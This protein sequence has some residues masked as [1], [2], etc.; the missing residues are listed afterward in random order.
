[1]FLPARLVPA[2]CSVP[3]VAAAR[4][5]QLAVGVHARH[6]AAGVVQQA[7]RARVQVAARQHRAGVGQRCSCVEVGPSAGEGDARVAQRAACVN[8]SAAPDCSRPSVVMKRSRAALAELACLR[9][10]HAAQPGIGAGAQAQILAGRGRGPAPATRAGGGACW[11]EAA[12]RIRSPRVA[13]K[14]R[15]PFKAAVVPSIDRPSPALSVWSRPAS[16][17]PAICIE[18]AAVAVGCRRPAP[19]P[20]PRR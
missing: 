2:C 13:V 8:A 19:G 3:A 9:G 15:S 1:M 18:P 20:C 10:D 12:P 11:R 16:A 14:V 7:R 17:R 5:A 6:E 4:L